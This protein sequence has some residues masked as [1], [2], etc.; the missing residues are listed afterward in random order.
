MR[1]TKTKTEPTAK[2]ELSSASDSFSSSSEEE[3]EEEAEII[4]R[5]MV[6]NRSSIIVSTTSI[7]SSNQM[8]V[9]LLFGD[10]I[11]SEAQVTKLEFSFK[12]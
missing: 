8:K 4:Y 2:E 9:A 7:K 11:K 10:K 5:E 12:I 3:E 6:D 1:K